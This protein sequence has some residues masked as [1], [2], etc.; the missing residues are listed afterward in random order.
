[1]LE[2]TSRLFLF[3]YYYDGAWWNF[4]LPARDEKEAVE[5]LGRIAT[6]RFD[7]EIFHKFELTQN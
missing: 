1:M 5:R 6:A 4:E 3:S 7:G 2:E